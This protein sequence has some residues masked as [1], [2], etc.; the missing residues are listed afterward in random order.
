MQE[1]SREV[2]LKIDE[3]CYSLVEEYS[4]YIDDTEKNVL[5][6]VLNEALRDYANVYSDLKKGYQEMAKTNLEISRAFID[7][8]NEAYQR[9]DD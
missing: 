3:D 6:R 5:N 4:D 1:S 9:I 8:E 7:S 2:T